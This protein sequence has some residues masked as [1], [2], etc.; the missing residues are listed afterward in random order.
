MENREKENNGIFDYPYAQVRVK[1]IGAHRG[2][3][4]CWECTVEM[5]GDDDGPFTT[6]VMHCS[7][8]E[9]AAGIAYERWK[10]R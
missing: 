2:I 1:P 8:M 7:S 9:N 4:D 10:I 3:T 5:E 6:K